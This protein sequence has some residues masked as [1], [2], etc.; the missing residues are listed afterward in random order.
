MTAIMRTVVQPYS[1][2]HPK[3]SSV[4]RWHGLW[5]M[6]VVIFSSSQRPCFQRAYVCMLVCFARG[7][8]GDLDFET[9]VPIMSLWPVPLPGNSPPRPR[10]LLSSSNVR[11]AIHAQCR[12][13]CTCFRKFR[14]YA[15]Y[16]T[17]DLNCVASLSSS[18][19][20]SL[21][22]CLRNLASGAEALSRQES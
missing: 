16:R 17:I 21:S 7:F 15:D 13:S 12:I 19:S 8:L 11:S 22:L 10:P 6:Q 14:W 18:P 20:S 1:L 4:P 2:E 5:D 3:S 9:H